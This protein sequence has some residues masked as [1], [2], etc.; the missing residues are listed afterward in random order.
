MSEQRLNG[1]AHLYI[2]D[3]IPVDYDAVLDEFGKG[4]RRLN[5]V[6]E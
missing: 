5:F 3:D 6:S 4:N 2:N 1:L